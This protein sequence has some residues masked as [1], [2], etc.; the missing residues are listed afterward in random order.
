MPFRNFDG[1]I[2]RGALNRLLQQ[3]DA[4]CLTRVIADGKPAYSWYALATAKFHTCIS[5]CIGKLSL[6]CCDTSSNLR[7]N[8]ENSIC[9]FTEFGSFFKVTWH[10]QPK[11][12]TRV[13][14]AEKG[15]DSDTLG[16]L[17]TI[18]TTYYYKLCCCLYTNYTTLPQSSCRLSAIAELLVAL[19]T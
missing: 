13:Y 17:I 1:Q 12:C 9:C 15:M 11:F 18:V 6:E 3:S 16:Q 14:L 7:Y 2:T 5:A 8:G 19:V 4:Y 10:H